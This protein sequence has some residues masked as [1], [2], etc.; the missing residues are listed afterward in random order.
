M[1][2]PVPV[3]APD[4]PAKSELASGLAVSVTDVPLANF[5]LQAEPQLIPEGLLVTLPPPVPA[6]WT[7][8]PIDKGEVATV[9]WGEPQPPRKIETR[10]TARRR[11]AT[12]VRVIQTSSESTAFEVLPRFDETSA[13]RY[14]TAGINS[15]AVLSAQQGGHELHFGF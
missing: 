3:Q 8:I 12:S 9:G 1:H 15:S 5:A 7:I 10:A 2:V 14:V 6:F 11:D 13:I 4:Q